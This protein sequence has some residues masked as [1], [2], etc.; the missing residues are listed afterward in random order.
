MYLPSKQAPMPKQAPITRAHHA[1]TCTHHFARCPTAG[2]I[3]VDLC[4]AC[5]SN[6]QSPN[7]L[8]AQGAPGLSVDTA[9]PG[10]VAPGTAHT[11]LASC[12][13]AVTTCTMHAHRKLVGADRLTCMRFGLTR[14][15]PQLDIRVGRQPTALRLPHGVDVSVLLARFTDHSRQ[16]PWCNCKHSHAKCGTECTQ[17]AS[18]GHV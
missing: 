7:R 11:R 1:H 8:L 3:S 18:H 14:M 9:L 13:H 12:T 17:M 15:D 6:T 4:L 16:A 10:R 2:P 5:M